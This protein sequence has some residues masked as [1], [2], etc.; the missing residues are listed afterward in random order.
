MVGSSD[1]DSSTRHGAVTSSLIDDEAECSAGGGGG[2]GEGTDTPGSLASFIASDSDDSGAS[3]PRAQA[4]ARAAAESEMNARDAGSG[5][6]RRLLVLSPPST[7]SQ[8]GRSRRAARPRQRRPRAKSTE[9]STAAAGQQHQEEAP[10]PSPSPAPRGAPDRNVADYADA[11]V[12]RDDPTWAQSEVKVGRCTSSDR[13]W[14]GDFPPGNSKYQVTWWSV[15]LSMKG[16]HIPGSWWAS[17]QRYTRTWCECGITNLEPGT[18]EKHIHVQGCW[19]L[20]WYPQGK[21]KLADHVKLGCGIMAGSGSYLVLTFMEGN[22]SPSAMAGYV[23]KS[24]GAIGSAQY[25]TP[26]IT[27]EHIDEGLVIWRAMNTDILKGKH[28]CGP[29]NF[30]KCYCAFTKSTLNGH[31][32]LPCEV[33]FAMMVQ[34]ELH[35]LQEEWCRCTQTH[36]GG[37]VNYRRFTILLKAASHPKT[38]TVRDAAMLIFN[39]NAEFAS[40]SDRT[41]AGNET[42]HA[43]SSGFRYFRPDENFVEVPRTKPRTIGYLSG[44]PENLHNN[45]NYEQLVEYCKGEM[46]VPS[47][48]TLQEQAAAAASTMPGAGWST[49]TS[50]AARAAEEPANT[51]A[52]ATAAVSTC[53]PTSIATA[54]APA[55]PPSPLCSPAPTVAAAATAAA[56]SPPRLSFSSSGELKSADV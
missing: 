6:V 40:A 8:G 50:A 42:E 54:F 23:S 35:T 33:V 41:P 52:V 43:P 21:K 18:Q 49:G 37:P 7:D 15:T 51:T 1:S 47:M 31:F 19:C 14:K 39:Q 3:S 56:T 30:L 27:Q 29:S 10:A 34:S 24:A 25:R 32:S 17:M 9:G 2:E 12:I 11:C 45:M 22:H 5:G 4:R 38:A 53:A 55:P 26:N 20:L 13:K 46:L 48:G 16:G 44:D 36:S 28:K